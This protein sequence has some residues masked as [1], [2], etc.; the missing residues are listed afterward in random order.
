MQ[1]E[2]KDLVCALRACWPDLSVESQ[3]DSWIAREGG[4]SREMNMD[5]VGVSVVSGKKYVC[6]SKFCT[7]FPAKA[8]PR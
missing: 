6:I 1:V 4:G 5:I 3:M 7:V 8:H 2:H